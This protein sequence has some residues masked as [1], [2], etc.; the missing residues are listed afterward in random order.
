MTGIRHRFLAA[1]GLAGA[2]ALGGCYDDGYYGGMSVGTGYY[3]GGGYYGDGYYGPTGY[4]QPGVY[5]GWY[6]DFYYPGTGYYVYD[7]GGRRHRWNDGQRRYWEGR[8]A[9]RRD[10]DRWR[11][12][13]RDRDGN[14][15]DRDGRPGNGNWTRP[16]R[17]PQATTPGTG[18]RDRNWGRDRTPGAGGD[19]NR[20][21]GNYGRGDSARPTPQPGAGQ[22]QMRPQPRPNPPQMSQPRPQR[23]WNPGAGPSR[24]GGGRPARTQQN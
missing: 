21:R 10:D 6:D 20:W 8:R 22:P 5:G 19:R 18:G 4:Y 11:G 16:T 1:I 2:L 17:P 12:R 9:E 14:W 13:D 3:G 7:R 24:S 23:S 15:R